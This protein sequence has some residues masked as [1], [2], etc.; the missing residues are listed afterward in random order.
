MRHILLVL[1]IL[2]LSGC[3]TTG[4]NFIDPPR[5]DKWSQSDIQVLADQDVQQLRGWWTR[6]KDP[7]LNK[8]VDMALAGSPDR[9]IAEARIAEARGLKRT[10]F[11]ALFPQVGGTGR[12]GREKTAAVDNES[13]YDA[14]FDASFEIDIFGKSRKANDA[15]FFDLQ[16]VEAS[17]HDVSL[18]LIADVA[19]A[20]I[21]YR[22]SSKQ[23]KIARK[24]LEIQERTLG[25]IRTRKDAGEA[26]Q[27]DVER[28][29]NLVNTTRS[30][31]PEFE[32][33]A[34][35][36]RL[37]LTVLTGA[38]PAETMPILAAEWA[39]PGA[40]VKPV[41]LAP[42]QVLALRPDIRAATAAF[43][44]GT[45]RAESTTAEIFPSFSLS[46]LYGVTDSALVDSVSI[47]NVA[48]GAAVTV[49][50]FGRIEGRI[51][52]ARAQEV[53]A[54]ETYRKAILVA[55]T[56]VERALN[57]Y[58]KVNQQRASLQ[59]AY[60][61]AERALTLSQQ[62]YREGEISFLDVLDAERTA[63]EADSAL[64]TAEVLQAES[65]IRLYKSLGV[66]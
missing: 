16:A 8:L 57:D 17:Y 12:T 43:N 27:L 54:F 59:A 48:L 9:R 1:A 6:F 36:A 29:E 10:A 64:I 5:P 40:D 38:L 33:Q 21:D 61:N 18:T 49:L 22:G 39:V 26:T 31:I 46:G 7:A 32:R 4:M 11:S 66:Y 56:D 34:E 55:V 41:L 65:L 53:Q 3:F 25:L 44:A 2:P 23:A 42:A 62:L 20:Y 35:N 60:N 51:D 24:N 28:S 37:Q 58:A 19:R 14:A 45:A 15:A 52:A 50:D 30:S 13:F 47:W 63:N